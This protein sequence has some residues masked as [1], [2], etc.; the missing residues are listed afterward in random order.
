MKSTTRILMF[1]AALL[2]G[3][4]IAGD[5]GAQSLSMP[6]F[7][8]RPFVGAYVPTGDQGDLLEAAATF[9]GQGSFAV[10]RRLSLVGTA[11]WSPSTMKQAPTGDDGVDVFQY[12]LGAEL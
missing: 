2:A 8:L 5:A 3:A 4:A 11:S 7:E 9:G 12:D 1:S 10:T 6:R